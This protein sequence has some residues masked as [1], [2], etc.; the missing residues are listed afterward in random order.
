MNRRRR[1]NFNRIDAPSL[2]RWIVIATFVAATGLSYVYLSVQ[3]HHQ[4][5]QRRLL[6]Q[7]LI[8]ARTQNEDARVQIATLTSRTALQRRL[9]EGYLKMIPIT[10]QSIVRLNSP[11]RP[12]G[13]DDLQPV[14][15]QRGD[16]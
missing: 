6:E 1:K 10:E 14:V 15:N 5:V 12:A 3:L 8:V 16:R 2:A 7:D 13:E 11:A 4:G 9:K